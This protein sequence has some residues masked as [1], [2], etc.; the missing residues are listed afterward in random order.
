MSKTS[1]GIIANPSAGK[2][3][4]RLVAHGRVVSNQEKSNVLRRVFAGINSTEVE[5]LVVMPD[6]SGLSR[7]GLSDI[8]NGMEVVHLDMPPAT[9]Q[10]ATTKAS[11]LMAEMGVGCIVTLGGDGTNR[12]VAK[13]CG[14][15]PILPISTGTN[16]VF[17]KMT[18]GTLAGI[19]AGNVASRHIPITESCKRSKKINIYV[20][21]KLTDISL[22]DVAVTTQMFLGARAVW[23]PKVIDSVFLTRSE[24]LSIGLSSIGA[25]LKTIYIDDPEGMAINFTGKPKI[26]ISAPVAPGIVEKLSISS[27]YQMKPN[28]FHSVNVQNGTVALD[29]EREVELLPDRRVEIA[30]DING[31]Y[32]VDEVTV[33]KGLA[34]R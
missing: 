33:L 2:D 14:E 5:Q 34:G 13:G 22:V 28:E 15:V 11:S 25:K 29:G 32:V 3:I 10:G 16:N 21:G 17:P 1:V 4:R 27:W 9:H 12:V 23:D 19:A 24:P 8:D 18:E 31:P 7:P 20:N 6:P 30:L 26:I